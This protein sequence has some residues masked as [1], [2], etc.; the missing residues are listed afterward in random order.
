[1][2]SELLPFVT[3]VIPCRNE[4]K[5]IAQCVESIA[6]EWVSLTDALAE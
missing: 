5:Y 3:L 2:Q 6:N 1:M 4:E